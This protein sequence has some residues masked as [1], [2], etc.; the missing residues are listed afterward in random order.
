M[1]IFSFRSVR[2]VVPGRVAL[3]SPVGTYS[4]GSRTIILTKLLPWNEISCVCSQ[5]MICF[6]YHHH[7]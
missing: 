7:I 4:A 2:D 6:F 5:L 3:T 1:T